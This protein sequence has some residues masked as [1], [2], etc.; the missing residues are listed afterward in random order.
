MIL[1]PQIPAWQRQ[2][3]RVQIK[4]QFSVER[5]NIIVQQVFDANVEKACSDLQD[6]ENQLKNALDWLGFAE[7]TLKEVKQHD[8][9]V[10]NEALNEY[11]ILTLENL[12]HQI[13]ENSV[14]ELIA[15]VERKGSL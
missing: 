9:Q 4:A 11:D 2:E 14:V 10:L 12:I 7:Q 5:V 3:Q 15:K 13:N 8:F 1:E 6:A